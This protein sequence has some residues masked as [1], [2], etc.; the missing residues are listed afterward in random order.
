MTKFLRIFLLTLFL[1]AVSRAGK[2]MIENG[3]LSAGAAGKTTLEIRTP[4][5]LGCE[6]KVKAGSLSTV[7]V[8]FEKWCQARTDDD[9]RRF[10]ELIDIR[11]DNEARRPD[12]IRL[13]VL[14]P[15]KAP[16]E[17]K[18]ESAGVNLSINVPLN[19]MIDSKSSFSTVD[20]VGPLAGAF[21]GNEYGDISVVDVNGQV[22]INTSYSHI[23]L[24]RIV[25]LVNIEADYSG[26][27][28]SDLELQGARG[29][30]ST[31]YG[32]VELRNIKGSLEVNTS[33]DA[34]SISRV[35]AGDGN[36][37][38]RTSYGRIDADD[39]IG[40]LVCETSFS[41]VNLCRLNLPH[42][43]SSIETKYSPIDVDVASLGDAKLTINNTYNNVNLSLPPDVSARV[44]LMVDRGGK[45]HTRGFPIK[46]V[47][48]NRNYLEGI[49]GD[50][51][52]LIEV[53]VDG[54]G[55]INLSG[56]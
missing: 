12:G 28:G 31:S 49:I 14:A 40:E 19:F 35:D 6:I 50:G 17:G 13:R 45:I 7:S 2:S 9:A 1:A 30:F 8:E 23:D 11:L 16:W 4:G 47:S 5:N 10:A 38:L 25:G 43:V 41:T 55:E 20:L 48:L 26:I 36:V 42:G 33:Y 34:I 22:D 29:V 24:S 53:T 3:H 52:S 21:I 37:I 27:E 46:P 54:I 51:R 56:R 15:A 39:V 18:N 32:A 44:S